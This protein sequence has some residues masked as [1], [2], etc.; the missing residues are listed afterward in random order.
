MSYAK[1]LFHCKYAKH[2]PNKQLYFNLLCIKSYYWLNMNLINWSHEYLNT[3]IFPVEDFGI[4]KCLPG[5]PGIFNEI[6]LND[7]DVLI[8]V[9]V[10]KFSV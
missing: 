8:S 5:Q 10:F 1:N 3:S 4:D 7:R 9:M 2:F 6:Q